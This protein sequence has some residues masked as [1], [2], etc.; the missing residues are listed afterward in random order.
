M[1][2]ATSSYRVWF[3]GDGLSSKPYLPAGFTAV[4]VNVGSGAAGDIVRHSY[5]FSEK[6][7]D[8]TTSFHFINN[9][10]DW[11]DSFVVGP[12]YNEF[13]LRATS[14][15]DIK[16]WDFVTY[17]NNL[18]I[19]YLKR[20]AG[21]TISL[22]LEKFDKYLN[23]EV[24]AY[25]E[26]H[27]TISISTNFLDAKIEQ[28]TDGNFIAVFNRDHNTPITMGYAKFNPTLSLIATGNLY[29]TGY[30]LYANWDIAKIPGTQKFSLTLGDS[31]SDGI[32]FRVYSNNCTFMCE[33]SRPNAHRFLYAEG[34]TSGNFAVFARDDVINHKLDLFL[35]TSA[36]GFNCSATVE[37]YSENFP[38]ANY[39]YGLFINKDLNKVITPYRWTTSYTNDYRGSYKMYELTGGVFSNLLSRTEFAGS[40]VDSACAV[41]DDNE[42]YVFFALM[43]NPAGGALKAKYSLMTYG[44]TA[45]YKESSSNLHTLEIPYASQARINP[46]TGKF[47]D[48]MVFYVSESTAGTASLQLVGDP[49]NLSSLDVAIGPTGEIENDWDSSQSQGD[50]IF[51]KIQEGGLFSVVTKGFA[52]VNPTGEF[53]MGV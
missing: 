49:N 24:S 10:H 41:F 48:N 28:L 33:S 47:S 30:A 43:S 4:E 34:M 2:D 23:M 6:I 36:A 38:Y 7:K 52:G 22:N 13:N 17:D 39:P 51:T 19:C 9:D 42:N 46:I 18:I 27:N 32:L 53:E 3:S 45:V 15:D 35:I 20:T 50:I 11:G 8:T 44:G 31:Q 1:Y 16:R 37:P 12:A 40:A 26:P 21:G 14:S 25:H 5:S 29:Y